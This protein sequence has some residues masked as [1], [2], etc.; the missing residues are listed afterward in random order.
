LEK[1]ELK[2]DKREKQIITRIIHTTADFG[3]ANNT[4]ISNGAIDEGI[5]AI[6]RG[7][8]IVT[9][10]RMAQVG[11][12][13][14]D[15]IKY[16][17]EINCFISDERVYK[18]AKERGITRSMAA[19]ELASQDPKNGIFV[20]GN[21]PTALFR[22]MEL[23]EEGKVNPSLVIGVPIGFVGAAQAKERLAVLPVPYITIK[24][25][26]G[27]SNIAVA[28]MNALILLANELV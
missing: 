23:F 19:M 25:R 6:K 2:F 24:G 9:D 14:R 1:R 20:F 18:I 7:V 11:I 3:F 10:T 26:K 16:G 12:R 5:R 21:A 27:G 8:G 15:L 17:S 4:I 22:L 28:I 13:K